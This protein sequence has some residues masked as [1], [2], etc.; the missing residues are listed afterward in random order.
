[1]TALNNILALEIVLHESEPS[2]NHVT[3]IE[4]IQ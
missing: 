4:T 3:K 2:Q 1:M